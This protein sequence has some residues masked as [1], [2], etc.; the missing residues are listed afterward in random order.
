MLDWLANLLSLCVP[1]KPLAQEGEGDGSRM[2]GADVV[3]MDSIGPTASL[4]K[5]CLHTN[6]KHTSK[7]LACVTCSP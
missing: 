3:K 1:G 7:H 6:H 5:L 4:L 2:A